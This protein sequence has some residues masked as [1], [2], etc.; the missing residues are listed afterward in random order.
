MSNGY[1]VVVSPQWALNETADH[2][3]T[4]SKGMLKAATSDNVQALA[5]LVVERFGATLAICQET[6]IKVETFASRSHT[7]Y[8]LEFLKARIGWAK[9]NATQ[10]LCKTN[11]AIR[12]LALAAALTT[13]TSFEA[14]QSI[15]LMLKS[16]AAAGQLTPTVLQLQVLVTALEYKLTRAGFAEELLKWHRHIAKQLPR[17]I[18]SNRR[19][20]EILQSATRYPPPDCLAAL[21][22]AFRSISRIG[23]AVR[24]EIWTGSSTPWVIAFTKW[25]LGAS[26]KIL[27]EDGTVILVD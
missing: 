21:V 10:A 13:W 6:E 24:I 8:V 22:E 2:F 5:I 7:S 12:F 19:I 9:G 14:A 3:I 17:H 27:L 26:P 15:E 16:N 23:G 1:S 25:C 18:A 11:G 20:R 4:I